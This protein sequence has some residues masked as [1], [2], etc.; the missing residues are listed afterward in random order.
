MLSSQRL[1]HGRRPSVPAWQPSIRQSLFRIIECMQYYTDHSQN[2]V[3]LEHGTCV[4]IADGLTDEQAEWAAKECLYR[5]CHA[6]PD[7][8]PLRMEDGNILVRY[9]DSVLNL[10][11]DE[12]VRK[13][14]TEIVRHHREALAADEVI[15]TPNGANLF[16]DLEMLALF[17]R[18][19][20]FMDAQNPK[21]VHIERRAVTETEMVRTAMP[22]SRGAGVA[23]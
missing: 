9:R 8:R 13:H 21:V 22:H 10:V 2:F 1:L 4:L 18:C 3:L 12:T 17:G 20:M 7:M 23:L 11:L 16:D 19:F 14:G 15:M 6:Y 5:I